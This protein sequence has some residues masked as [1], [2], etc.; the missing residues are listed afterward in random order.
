M[1]LYG[2]ICAFALILIMIGVAIMLHREYKDAQ[3]PKPKDQ[4][5][6]DQ[7]T[8]DLPYWFDHPFECTCEGCTTHH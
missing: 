5:H 1:V 7:H 6:T 4:A 3:S 8:L 2:L